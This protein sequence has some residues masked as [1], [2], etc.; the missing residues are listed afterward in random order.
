MQDFPEQNFSKGSY[1][2]QI[3]AFKIY[4]NARELAEKFESSFEFSVSIEFDD[5]LYKVR[6]GVYKDRPEA[7]KQKEFIESNGWN[8]F[9][10]FVDKS[11]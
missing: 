11:K 10:V 9:L 6:T 4:R 3:G 2:I 1:S 7:L 8:C 5:D